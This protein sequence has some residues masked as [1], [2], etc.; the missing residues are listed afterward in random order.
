MRCYTYMFLRHACAFLT[1]GKHGLYRK[2]EP[3]VFSASPY[4]TNLL[5]HS[6]MYPSQSQAALAGKRSSLARSCLPSRHLI[7]PPP[8]SFQARLGQPNVTQC[9]VGVPCTAL[10]L[11]S[12]RRTQARDVLTPRV[13]T[14]VT[15]HTYSQAS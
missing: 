14:L 8:P 4:T 13:E 11:P 1:Y 2:C 12:G 10:I 3:D 5:A 6:R 15:F 7:P 9:V